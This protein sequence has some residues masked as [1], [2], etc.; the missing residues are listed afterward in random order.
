MVAAAVLD[1]TSF[2]L[3]SHVQNALAASEVDVG[4]REVV[5]AFVISV[6]I[7]VIDEGVDLVSQIAG[8]VIVFQQDAV[9]Q[10]LVPS[11]DLALG[12]RVMRG[13]TD[14]IDALVLKIVGQV[15]GDVR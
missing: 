10:R 15:G 13:A 5:E 4:R 3:L 2:D 12:L 9:L 7:V 6:M 1:G 11:L 8:Q 14:V